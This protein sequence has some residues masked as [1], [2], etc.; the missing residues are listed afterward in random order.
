[1]I[2]CRPVKQ[3]NDT[4]AIASTDNTINNNSPSSTSA[5]NN[6]TSNS[7]NSLEKSNPINHP[8]SNDQ[9]TPTGLTKDNTTHEIAQ[10]EI[11]NPLSDAKMKS[12]DTSSKILKL[13]IVRILYLKNHLL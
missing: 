12:K 7:K 5:Q 6:D 2:A 11:I 4:S 8:T 9:P 3:I 13:K 1:M 10:N